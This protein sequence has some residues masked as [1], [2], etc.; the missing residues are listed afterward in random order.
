MVSDVLVRY[1]RALRNSLGSNIETL[2]RLM[3]DHV[4]A[5]E[6]KVSSDFTK[7]NVPLKDMNLKEN[8]LI[9]GIIRDKKPIIP[10]G[11]DVILAGDK[12]IIIAAD[13]KIQELSD[14]LK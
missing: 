4:E 1:A 11:N 14:I 12:I 3:D 8:I 13:R 5:I 2:Y 6:F 9:A 7:I 10:T